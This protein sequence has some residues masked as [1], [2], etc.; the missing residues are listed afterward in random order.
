M[1][2]KKKK[3]QS[4]KQHN[5][6]DDHKHGSE[7][8]TARTSEH[9]TT[10]ATPTGDD[11]EHNNHNDSNEAER[12]SRDAEARAK[13]EAELEELRRERDALESK[14]A[15][16]QAQLTASQEAVRA[17]H[18][19]Q[20]MQKVSNMLDDFRQQLQDRKVIVLPSPS[21]SA[22]SSSSLHNQARTATPASSPTKI[23]GR[24]ERGRLVALIDLFLQDKS[25][26]A[27]LPIDMKNDAVVYECF[28]I[29]K[30]RVN[31]HERHTDKLL[32]RHE[33]I[34]SEIDL[35]KSKL[36]DQ[37][38]LAAL[39]EARRNEAE[40]R[41][42][43]LERVQREQLEKERAMGEEAKDFRATLERGIEILKHGRHGAPH[44][45][46]VILRDGNKLFWYADKQNKFVR[47]SAITAVKEGL[48]TDVLK[49]LDASRGSRCFSLITA[50]RT[51]NFEAKTPAAQKFWVRGMRALLATTPK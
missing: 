18:G 14:N 5:S 1:K 20:A 27:V 28:N 24:K 23:I 22:S 40:A 19:A 33:S 6:E 44:M 13:F 42:T 45:R 9:E 10:T 35:L 15:R 17:R 38:Q 50:T 29:L 51:L 2:K 37:E 39:H 11:D 12:K 30:D 31:E 46:K 3:K 25:P 26:N 16:L 48:V 43:E 21:A 4:K 47:L 34:S 8:T 7:T 41:A 36:D 32:T 49:K